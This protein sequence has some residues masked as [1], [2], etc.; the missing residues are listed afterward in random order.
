MLRE[1]IVEQTF[2]DIL[3]MLRKLRDSGVQVKRM[4]DVGC[5]DGKRTLAYGEMFGLDKREMCGVECFDEQIV[6]AASRITACKVD[7][8]TEALPFEDAEFDLVVCNQVFEHLKQIYTPMSEIH[9]VLAPEG[10]LIFSVPNL[11]SLHSR[12]MLMAGYQPTSIRVIG[13]HVRGFTRRATKQFLELNRLFRVVSEIGV[14]FYPLP[15]KLAIPF[16]RLMPSLSHTVIF[17]AKSVIGTGPN[18]A[19]VM[20]ARKEQTNFF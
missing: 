8:E 14:G 17:L 20:R 12:L 15:M 11:A 2:L 4:L 10:A 13:P 3:G 19:E 18:W 6:L 7:L 16:A 5:W 1:E 9:R